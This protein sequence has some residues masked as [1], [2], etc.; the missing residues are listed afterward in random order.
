MK[1]SKY[2]NKYVRITDKW[3][4]T[5]TG[6]ASYGGSEFL[7]HEFGGDEEGL[8][9]EDV[10]IYKSQIESIE[11]IVSA[12]MPD[13]EGLSGNRFVRKIVSLIKPENSVS[14]IE[15]ISMYE[16]KMEEAG[17]LI[18]EGCASEKLASL[19]DELEAYY[20]SPQWKQDYADDEAGRLPGDLKRGI[21]SEDGLFNLF[22]EYNDMIHGN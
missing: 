6:I 15:R 22:E 2:D 11:E 10:L 17:R 3:G 21:L 12:D 16:N 5:F 14:Q 7:M 1:L 9:I 13:T 19:I 18:K 4:E 8:F 20:A